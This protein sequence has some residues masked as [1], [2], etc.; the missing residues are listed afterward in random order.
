M[1]TVSLLSPSPCLQNCCQ[2]RQMMCPGEQL[3]LLQTTEYSTNCLQGMNPCAG[4][5]SS[6]SKYKLSNE[7]TC[8]KEP[9]TSISSTLHILNLTN[10]SCIYTLKET[11]VN[12]EFEL[13]RFLLM[14][15]SNLNCP[16]TFEPRPHNCVLILTHSL[17]D[18][19][20]EW[21]TRYKVLTVFKNILHGK[22]KPFIF[23][24]YSWIHYRPMY[25]WER[26]CIHNYC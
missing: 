2:S 4:F 22:L 20:K 18:N 6:L 13:Y 25:M 15:L 17:Q 11:L 16:F 10:Y 23:M 24:C 3:F 14:S 5:Q 9:H 8:K 26:C 1:T 21:K 19:W 12:S 7:P